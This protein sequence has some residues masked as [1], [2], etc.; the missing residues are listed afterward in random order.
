MTVTQ[1]APT[2]G[3]MCPQ[4]S[5]R[6]PLASIR[7]ESGSSP[8]LSPE[9]AIARYERKWFR[10]AEEEERRVAQLRVRDRD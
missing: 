6:M 9:S 10:R 3:H 5:P 1:L 8:S 4:T 7:G 2:Y